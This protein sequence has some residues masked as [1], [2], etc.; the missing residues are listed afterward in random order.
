MLPFLLPCLLLLLPSPP[1]PSPSLTLPFLLQLQLLRSIT[2]GANT[3]IVYEHKMR[4]YDKW[5]VSEHGLQTMSEPYIPEEGCEGALF[6]KQ[7]DECGVCLEPMHASATRCA[8]GHFF[9]DSCVVAI[10]NDRGG[11]CP[12][13]CKQRVSATT[14]RRCVVGAKGEQKEG[15]GNGGKEGEE[16]GK[17]GNEEK[18][19]GGKRIGEQKEEGGKRRRGREEEA[20]GIR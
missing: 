19:E 14:A 12:Y 11:K 9:C 3:L 18:G 15:E 1:P 17:Q 10:I 13:F 6:W 4:E 20:V 8:C 7:G 16:G 2:H 5:Y